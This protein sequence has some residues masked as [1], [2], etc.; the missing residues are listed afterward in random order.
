MKCPVCDRENMSMLCTQCGFD[1]SQDYRKYPTFG[2]VGRVPAISVL[3]KQWKEKHNPAK[4]AN[5]TAPKRVTKP[6][7]P[8]QP[9]SA[10]RPQ[11][12]PA[13]SI[14][15]NDSAHTTVS[16]PTFAPVPKNKWTA[17]FLCFFLGM[18][19]CHKFYEG[20]KGMGIL[21]LCTFGLFGYGWLFDWIMLLFKPNPYFPVSA[22]SR[23]K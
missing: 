15:V 19:G 20:K 7:V 17:F 14:P 16:A 5:R 6:V 10:N 12:Q 1:A 2:P 13:D 23:L 4:P 18:F 11:H 3:R 8:L 21:Y 22:Q 9:A